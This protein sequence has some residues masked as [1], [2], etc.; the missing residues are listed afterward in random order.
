MH[1]QAQWESAMVISACFPPSSALSSTPSTLDHNWRLLVPVKRVLSGNIKNK[2][3]TSFERNI[4]AF[5]VYPL[6]LTL[7]LLFFS[8]L[9]CYAEKFQV[10]VGCQARFRTIDCKTNCPVFCH[11][12]FNFCVQKKKNNIKKELILT[13]TSTI[14]QQTMKLL[15]CQP[16]VM[17]QRWLQIWKRYCVAFRMC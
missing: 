7:W 14:Q 1:F 8:C 4:Q 11:W 5:I 9:L 15:S 6:R 16:Y 13:G 17:R 2:L 3:T 12:Q 10:P